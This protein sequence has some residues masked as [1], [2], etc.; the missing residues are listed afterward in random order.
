MSTVLITGANRGLGLEFATQYAREGWHVYATC[1]KAMDLP[2]IQAL[3]SLGQVE[4]HVLDVSDHAAIDALS[5]SLANASIDVL[6]NNAGL[7]GPKAH[8][9][10][11]LR[12]SFGHMDYDIWQSVLRV[13]LMAPLK[14]MEAFVEQVARSDQ[15]K[16]VS[17]SSTE[18]SIAGAGGG[19]YAYKSS[20]AALNMIMSNAARDL[21]DRGI[22]TMAICPGWVRTRMGGDGGM[23]EAPESIAAV[24]KLIAGLKPKRSGSFVEYSGKTVPY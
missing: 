19:I 9:E 11:D 7:F 8:A 6:L 5:A 24:R 13:N 2:A 3:E 15:R 22:S 20:K 1:R 18:G 21:A 4:G 16:M 17:I 12:Q 14:M 10:Q 23:L